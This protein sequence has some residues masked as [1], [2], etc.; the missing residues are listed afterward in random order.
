M[1]AVISGI[2]E[3]DY[4]RSAS[5][6]MSGTDMQLL[7]ID[8]ALKDAGLQASQLDGVVVPTGGLDSDKLAALLGLPDIRFVANVDLGGAAGVAAIGVAGMALSEGVANHVLVVGGWLGYSKKRASDLM[9]DP[10]GASLTRSSIL[11]DYY[12]PHGA[13]TPVAWY[14]LM[15]R[16]HI[17]EYGT[18]PEQL[19]RV[20]ITA[21]CHAK[22][23]PKA[24]LRDRPLDMPSYLDSPFV[25][26]P[27]RVADCCLETDGMAAIIVSRDDYGVDTRHPV[28]VMSVEQARPDPPDDFISRRSLHSSIG[29]ARAAP[30]ALGRAGISP[31]ELDFAQ[32]YDCFTFEVIQQ[33][34]AIGMC[35]VGE[36]GEFVEEAG[37]GRSGVLPV[38]THGGLL[39]EAHVLGL[40]HLVEAVRQLRGEAGDRQLRVAELGVVTGWGDLGD[41]SIAVLG[42]AS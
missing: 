13:M 23:N 18:T 37:I 36:G 25:C 24:V 2:G 28:G 40:N 32:I 10:A 29:L 12:L 20:A 9:R 21:R 41:G 14:A 34:E 4:T 11:R 26:D 7:A 31:S 16:R 8:R 1:E 15:A 39:S 27:Y 17:H 35:G 42:N 38:N 33:I 5:Q 6:P 22:L 3:S 19:G 30:R